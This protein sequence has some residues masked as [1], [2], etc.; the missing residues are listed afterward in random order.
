MIVSRVGIRWKA[1]KELLS[2]GW[3]MLLL[4]GKKQ[5]KKV[6]ID[7]ASKQKNMCRHGTK[8]YTKHCWRTEVFWAIFLPRKILAFVG[9]CGTNYTAIY[10][11]KIVYSVIVCRTIAVQIALCSK[12]GLCDFTINSI[13]Q[14][15]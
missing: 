6:T 4:L 13:I 3:V 15:K 1:K 2:T 10:M 8:V 7:I 9:H 12:E 5:G 11:K 14:P